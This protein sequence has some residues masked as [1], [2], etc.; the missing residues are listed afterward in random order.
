MLKSKV[1]AI[2]VSQ[3]DFSNIFHVFWHPRRSIK[4]H[5]PKA[6]LLKR[7]T[8]S[9]TSLKRPSAARH[10]EPKGAK[11]KRDETPKKRPAKAEKQEKTVKDTVKEKKHES[12]VEE[13]FSQKDAE[14]QIEEGEESEQPEIDLCESPTEQEPH[15]E[16]PK[17]DK[18]GPPPPDDWMKRPAAT[19]EPQVGNEGTRGQI[20]STVEYKSGWKIVKHKTQKGRVYSKWI[21]PSDGRSFF[22]A[23]SASENGFQEE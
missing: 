1:L 9:T 14:V 17:S 21:R 12:K 6:V 4:G 13:T 3:K 15:P 11:T 5:R 19:A 16:P 23:K 20:I 10:V 22:S 8:T 2:S 7:E 18:R